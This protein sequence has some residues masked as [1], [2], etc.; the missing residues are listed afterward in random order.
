MTE[1]EIIKERLEQV[2][3]EKKQKETEKEGEYSQIFNKT[4]DSEQYRGFYKQMGLYLYL[5]RYIV[6]KPYKGDILNIYKHYRKKG[7]L[8]AHRSQRQIIRDL[9]MRG[10]ELQRATKILEEVGAINIE[11][12]ETNWS[13]GMKKP[14]VYILGEVKGEQ[15]TYYIDTVGGRKKRC[16]MMTLA[17]Q[18]DDASGAK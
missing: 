14:F 11:S 16:I 17:V 10:R 7:Y 18:N 13:S 3:G 2:R 5:R 15:T 6:R 9:G 4:I 8:A 1:E 12:L